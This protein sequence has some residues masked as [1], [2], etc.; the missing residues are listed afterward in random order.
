MKVVD[1]TRDGRREREILTGMVVNP[2]VLG[3]VASKWEDPGLFSSPWANL[4]GKWCVDFH[5]EHQQP[6]ARGIESLFQTWAETNQDEKLIRSVEAF[7][8][9]ISDEYEHSDGINPEYLLDVAGK[10]FNKVRLQKI[11]DE[12]DSDL[13]AND[14]NQAELR[15]SNFH[16]VELGVGAGLDL[17]TDE[18]SFVSLCSEPPEVLI[19]YPGPLGTFFGASLRRGALVAFLAPEK[20]G[21][22]FWLVDAAYRAVLERRKVA[23]FSVGDMTEQEIALRF[24]S[25]ACLKPYQSPTTR[26]PYVISYPKQI[27]PPT[28]K[29]DDK[30]AEVVHEDRVFNEPLTSRDAL[31]ACKRIMKEKVRSK[32]SFFKLVF[33]PTSSIDVAGIRST[34]DSWA[35]DGW[36]PDI[37]VIDYADILATPAGKFHNERDPINA[38]WKAL[39]RLSQETHALVLTASQAD[40]ASYGAWMLTRKNFNGDK[41]ILAHVDGMVGINATDI[42]REKDI[43]RLNWIVRR[44]GGY[45]SRRFVHVAGCLGLSFPSV[46]STF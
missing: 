15:V 46:R 40:A 30:S 24:Y 18:T 12:V 39:R 6:P 5:R 42:E 32:R 38:T 22:T 8:T 4:V 45:S 10:Y 25:R 17:F 23:F 26:W 34:L 27:S 9:S 2:L 41:R 29:E 31:K 35:L 21:K 13:Q 19:H 14:L 7:L 3:R 28:G 20:V 11:I 16:R 43:R 1:G 44:E 37:V 33:R 36:V